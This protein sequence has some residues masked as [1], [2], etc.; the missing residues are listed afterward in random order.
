M[1]FFIHDGR[2]LLVRWPGEYIGGWAF[3]FIHGEGFV[4]KK[5]RI[6]EIDSALLVFGCARFI[7]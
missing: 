4:K 6:G 7:D 1:W 3:L 5:R 2:D